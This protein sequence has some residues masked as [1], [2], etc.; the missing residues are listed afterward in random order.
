MAVIRDVIPAFELYQPAGI[1][2]AIRL[3]EKHGADALGLPASGG[4][5]QVR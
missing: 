4:P 5:A 1:D 2:E 3:L